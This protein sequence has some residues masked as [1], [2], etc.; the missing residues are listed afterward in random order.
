MS[1]LV[2]ILELVGGHL[3]PLTLV[4]LAAGCVFA[5]L[6]GRSVTKRIEVVIDSATRGAVGD[7]SQEEGQE[8]VVATGEL[9]RLVDAFAGI[10]MYMEELAALA[11]RVAAG[12]LTREG[13]TRWDQAG[14]VQGF[15]YIILGFRKMVTELA[16]AADS[17]AETASQVNE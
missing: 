16:K 14:L 11:D 10:R 6:V 3:G 8:T 9:G 12:H 7:L 2:A 4:V 15:L 5:I 1:A 17:V 13:A